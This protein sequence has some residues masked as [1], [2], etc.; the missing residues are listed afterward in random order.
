VVGESLVEQGL[1][2]LIVS[3]QLAELI[4]KKLEWLGFFSLSSHV[5]VDDAEVRFGSEVIEVTLDCR[6]VDACAL[7]VDFDFRA[8]INLRPEVLDGE[9]RLTSDGI[10][11]NLD[12]TDTIF[13]ALTSILTGPL[14]VILLTIGSVIAA[15]I[16]VSFNRKRPGFWQGPRLPGTEVFPRI[17]LQ[18]VA[19]STGSVSAAGAWYLAPDE[20]TTFVVV[21]VLS[22]NETTGE[23]SIAED[24]TVDLLELG[25]PAPA[26]DD[27]VPVSTNTGER[28]EG[29]G[30]VV[31]ITQ[32]DAFTFG[33]VLLATTTTERHGL[34][35]F[36]VQPDL[37][38]GMM[39]VTTKRTTP[40]GQAFTIH[41]R[42]PTPGDAPDLAVTITLSDGFQP[43]IRQPIAV[44]LADHHLGSIQ[45]PV[46]VVY[47]DR[48]LAERHASE[49]AKAAVDKIQADLKELRDELDRA[50]ASEKDAIRRGIDRLEKQFL[51]PALHT[52]AAA[53]AARD[54][55]EAQSPF[56]S[57]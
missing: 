4:S 17:D 27:Y 42:E 36:A 18:R 28:V 46:R 33:D 40:A 39:D 50:P 1:R 48:C 26:G 34:A 12:N 35:R 13:C 21:Q 32:T 44:N 55:C 31:T 57:A 47:L 20:A 16:S 37:V 41:S 8:S 23:V 51:D 24:V 2:A 9:L 19:A 25:A 11:L 15:V 38:G 22:M 52:L 30:T 6:L 10:N 7:S 53:R 49:A 3:G 56:L 29:D 54:S 45:E 14:G 5:E 43:I